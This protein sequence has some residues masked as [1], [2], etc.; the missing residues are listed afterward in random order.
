MNV[1]ELPLLGVR[2]SGMKKNLVST[3]IAI[4][5]FFLLTL[6]SVRAQ[7]VTNWNL[8]GT[9]QGQFYVQEG[10]YSFTLIV[11]SENFRTGA[12]SGTFNGV[13]ISGSISGNSYQFGVP[14]L[15]GYGGGFSGTLPAN[16][17]LSGYMY[18]TTTGGVWNG[19]FWTTSG[20]AVQGPGVVVSPSPIYGSD[21]AVGTISLPYIPTSNVTV[22]LTSSNPAVTVPDRVT[23]K[24]GSTNSQFTL[25]TKNVGIATSGHIK[26]TYEGVTEETVVEV[27][28]LTVASLSLGAS[29]VVGGQSTTLQVTLVAPAGPNGVVVTFSSSN[30]KMAITQGSILVPSGQTTATVTVLTSSPITAATT[31]YFGA[32]VEG[33]SMRI[34]L[35]V[36]P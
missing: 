26:A 14:Y 31:V 6:T 8:C 4:L 3:I 12:F 21:T 15:G 22:A 19:W 20:L 24:A 7:T 13:S 30:P 2:K 17:D 35:T 11:T 32:T 16:G 36:T 23:I 5:A 27:L 10:D 33:D 28:P 9:Y 34:V 25:T 18:Y 1:I 29:S